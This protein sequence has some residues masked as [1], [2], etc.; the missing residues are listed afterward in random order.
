MTSLGAEHQKEELSLGGLP[1][2]RSL[3]PPEYEA[4]DDE[5]VEISRLHLTASKSTTDSLPEYESVPRSGAASTSSCSS[6]SATGPNATHVFQVDTE[7][8]PLFALPTSPR[9]DPVHVYSVLPTGEIGP[10]VYQSIREKRNSGSCTLVRAGHGGQSQAPVCSTTYRFGPYR[11]PKMRLLG[12][13]TRE[14]D[15]EVRGRGC[16]TRA[17]NIRTHLGTFQWRYASR[18]ERK[19]VG[20]SSL[21]VLDLMATAAAAGGKQGESRTAVA[22]LVRNEAFR[23]RDTGVTTAG[24]GGR[25]SMDLRNWVD[26]KGETQ[27]VQVL[28]IASCITMLKKEVDRRR[29]H[30]LMAIAGGASGGG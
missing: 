13:V 26:A 30:Q 16:H 29:M 5:G 8:H 1:P 21:L 28:A 9:P 15:F 22:H 20:A 6:S 4:V 12:D 17:Q 2:R 7:G 11:P 10:E 23:T 27:Q 24:N 19:A 14:E 3:L 18:S 25:L